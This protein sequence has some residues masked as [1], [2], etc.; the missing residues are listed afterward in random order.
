MD[1]VRERRAWE[2]RVARSAPADLDVDEDIESTEDVE[3]RENGMVPLTEEDEIEALAQ[4]MLDNE[5]QNPRLQEKGGLDGNWEE[6]GQRQ[7]LHGPSASW[8]GGHMSCGS[9][10]EDYDQL[11]MEMISHSEEQGDPR[12]EPAQQQQCNQDLGFHRISEPPT[13]SMDL[14]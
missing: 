13:S 8:C 4:Y 5:V 3:V 14:S 9:D 6:Q 11:F 2:E 10:E 1:F 7:Q 12:Q